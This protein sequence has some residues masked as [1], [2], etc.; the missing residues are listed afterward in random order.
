VT[1]DSQLVLTGRYGDAEHKPDQTL[2]ADFRTCKVLSV[3]FEAYRAED[4]FLESAALSSQGWLAVGRGRLENN[5][6]STA[7]IVVIEPG[8]GT[9]RV[10]GH[11]V[12]PAWSRDGEWLA[13]TA[14]DG[15]HVVRKDGSQLRRVVELNVPPYSGVP[16]VWSE[17][18]SVAAWSPDGEWLVYHRVTG[19]SV[20]IYKVNV[21]SGVE[22]AIFEG[23]KLPHWRWD[24]ETTDE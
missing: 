11:G 23:G 6:R 24:V 1:S 19:H 21:A 18:V 3:L 17:D 22:T 9:Q 7:D 20:I 13:F 14:S 12:A 8:G 5:I 4:E 15:I 16:Y 10:V 2:L